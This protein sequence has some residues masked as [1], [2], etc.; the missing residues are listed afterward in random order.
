MVRDAYSARNH[1]EFHCFKI[2]PSLGSKTLGRIAVGRRAVSVT[3]GIETENPRQSGT[4]CG[5][6]HADLAIPYQR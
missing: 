4:N 1:G 2:P 3:V 6:L 5:H